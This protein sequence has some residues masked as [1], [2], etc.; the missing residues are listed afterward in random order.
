MKNVLVVGGAGYIGGAV[1]DILSSG[2]YKQRVYDNLLYDESYRKPVD[3]VQGDILDTK[4]LIPH[5]KW[6]DCVIWLAAI[7]GDGAC[8]LDE[9]LT[10]KVNQESVKWL[11]GHFDGRIIYTSTCSVYGA[12]Q[13]RLLSETSQTNP[14]SLYASTK[15]N[16]EK[17]L[18][19]K[20]A[21]I[22]RLGTLFGVSDHFAR[23]RMDLVVNLMTARAFA[24]HQIGVFGGEQYRPLVHVKDVGKVICNEI[25]SKT[26]GIY[27]ISSENVNMTELAKRIKK[28]FPKL[29]VV[30]TSSS[31]EDTRDYR[32]S[33]K[34]AQKEL[35]FEP[36]FSVDYGIQELIDLLSSGRVKD[37]NN[38]R[39]S[40]MLFLKEVFR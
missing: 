22:L 21:M 12:A 24:T 38:I 32:V 31:V 2:Q 1:T 6:A 9:I 35:L 39:Y 3:F 30:R 34:K 36:A 10:L 20:N 28:F 4:K 18:Q 27:N 29:T 16:S 40:N 13:K 25:N 7:V 11:A 33:T 37:L 8:K 23:I 15:L 19:R 17:Y 14:L 5:L 26:K